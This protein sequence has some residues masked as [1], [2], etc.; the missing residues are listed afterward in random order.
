MTTVATSQ[1]SAI[2][3]I[4]R[5]PGY[6]VVSAVARLAW[7]SMASSMLPRVLLTTQVMST[8]WGM[9]SSR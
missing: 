6:K 3:T 5:E 9:I 4:D 7:N 2:S 1:V 8:V